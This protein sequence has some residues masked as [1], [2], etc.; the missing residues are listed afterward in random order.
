MFDITK[1]EIENFRS[2]RGIHSLEVP[3]T[4]GLY[5][6]TGQNLKHPNLGANATGKSTLLEAIHWCN[7]G[8]TTRGLRASSIVNWYEKSCAVRLHQFIG[9]THLLVERSHSPNSLILNAKPVDQ[10]TLQNYLCLGPEAFPHAIMFPQ[11]GSAFFDLSPS[12]KLTLFSDINALGFW[13]KKSKEATELLVGLNTDKTQVEKQLAHHKGQIETVEADLAQLNKSHKEFDANQKASLNE[14]AI[15]IAEAEKI[16]EGLKSELGKT[17]GLLKLARRKY[18]IIDGELDEHTKKQTEIKNKAQGQLAKKLMV[19]NNLS[20]IEIVLKRLKGMK[21]ECPA[22]LQRVDVA[23][24]TR[25]KTRYG[26]QYK[27]TMLELEICVEAA[28]QIT[29][30]LDE[31]GNLIETTSNDL[32]AVEKNISDFE[33]HSQR[34]RLRIEQANDTL[35]QLIR[36]SVT[37]RTKPNPYA[38]MIADKKAS[39]TALLANI[40]NAEASIALLEADQAA[41]SYWVGGFKR[42]RLLVIEETLRQLEL[43]VNNNLASL[44]LLDWQIELDIERE[45]KSGGITKGFTVL[46][47]APGHKEPV[48]FE[49]WSGGETQRLRLAGNLGLANLI[50]ERAGL[51]STI[52]FYDEPS[53]HLSQEGILDLAETLHERAITTGKRIFVVEHNLPDYPYTGTIK[54]IKDNEGSHIEV[55]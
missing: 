39:Q 3:K 30:E 55:Q 46:V 21:A 36:Q 8:Y 4:R 48:K 29:D 38:K 20:T 6:I 18:N 16:M 24:L 22:C 23:H 9:S 32:T 37:E 45:N 54:I 40:K 34:S 11:F 17:S 14:I 10:T 50:M 47:R 41:V 49:A 13:I 1:I 12:D 27:A 42:I 26:K 25:E 44:G 31:I 52:E 28:S 43:E 19:E 15:R 53:R 5:A 7:Y 51:R 35:Q 2:F 33:A